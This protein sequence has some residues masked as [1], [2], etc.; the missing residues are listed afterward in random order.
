MRRETK[1]RSP[2]AL[3]LGRLP[4]TELHFRVQAPDLDLPADTEVGFSKDI[5][6]DVTVEEIV[7]GARLRVRTTTLAAAEC[8]RCLVVYELPLRATFDAV[9]R[10]GD[11]D[12]GDGIVCVDP[13]NPV[14]D[15]GPLVREA[16]L[17]EVPMTRVCRP[18][19]AGLCPGC[20]A[21]LNQ[22]TCRC[23]PGD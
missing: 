4:T 15:L 13:R 3:D 17:L 19:C 7:G 14:V 8:F 23:R 9:C 11:G 2:L 12:H 10:L 22:E 6:V 1:G 5:D 20:G 16:L 18:D 21:D